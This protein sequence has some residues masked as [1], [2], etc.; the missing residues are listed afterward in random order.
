MNRLVSD[1]EEIKIDHPQEMKKDVN[2][3][4]NGR[5]FNNQTQITHYEDIPNTMEGEN[6]AFD[7][8][9]PEYGKTNEAQIY[10]HPTDP[11][12]DFDKFATNLRSP[13]DTVLSP[14]G[15][16]INVNQNYPVRD[17]I[18]MIESQRAMTQ[19]KSS[20]QKLRKNL[21]KEN[22]SEAADYN[23]FQRRESKLSGPLPQLNQL[24]V[25][26]NADKVKIPDI[27][28]NR[29]SQRHFNGPQAQ[30][31]VKLRTELKTDK[32]LIANKI[33]DEMTMGLTQF[34]DLEMA[35]TKVVS[36]KEYLKKSK[37]QKKLYNV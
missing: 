12:S 27:D 19:I 3:F 36:Q 7:I 9:N 8:Y 17:K 5:N 28:E 34:P 2:I 31:T 10:S 24:H 13:D 14:H 25:K 20:K 11:H 21:N 29:S 23:R 33:Q 4:E 30:L 15:S 32:K 1:F 35:P 18:A 16:N 22:Q 37:R 26:N 6:A